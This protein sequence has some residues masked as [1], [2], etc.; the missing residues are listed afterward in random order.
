MAID[1]LDEAFQGY[2]DVE[3]PALRALFRTYLDLTAYQ[4]IRLKPFVRRDLFRRIVGEQFVNLTHV[5]A[6]KIEVI[7][8][9]DDL[10]SLLCRRVRQNRN[11][12]EKVGLLSL[13]DRELFGRLFP[14]QV[15]QGA[16]RPQTWVWMMSRI[17]DDNDIKPPRNLIDLVSFA[18]DAQLRR[19]DRE[20]RQFDPKQPIIEAESLRRALAQLSET[21]VSD[22]LLA[23]AKT[24]P[25]KLRSF[26]EERPSTTRS[27]YRI[28]S[29]CRSA[30]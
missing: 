20:P 27:H 28:L 7:W 10:L 26:V 25:P 12:C 19:E 13:S 1:R 8:D 29:T 4:S 18:R 30:K 2:P 16:R 11:F 15:D 9:E 3:I 22:T 21:R 14:D 17:R 6:Q 5:N 24:K 23:E